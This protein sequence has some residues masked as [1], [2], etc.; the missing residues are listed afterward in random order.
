MPAD[1]LADHLASPSN[2]I[3]LSDIHEQRRDL[4][5]CLN[6]QSL[7]VFRPSH[8]G[9]DVKAAPSE[10]QGNRPTHSAGGAGHERVSIVAL[11]YQTPFVVMPTDVCQQ[12]LA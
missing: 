1:V 6:L 8:S 2:L 11:H 7:A 12:V 5:D 3:R 4:S 9:E 10:P